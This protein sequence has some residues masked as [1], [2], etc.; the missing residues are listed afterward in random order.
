[1]LDQ[2]FGQP[3]VWNGMAT[4]KA[5]ATFGIVKS[6][7]AESFALETGGQRGATAVGDALAKDVLHTSGYTAPGFLTFDIA[8]DGF[9]QNGTGDLVLSL[10]DNFQSLDCEVV[11]TSTGN[12]TC[13]TTIKVS[14][15]SPI[16]LQL[17]LSSSVGL[18]LTVSAGGSGNIS[19][20]ADFSQTGLI[21][22]IEA[23]DINMQPISGVAITAD[24]GAVYPL[25]VAQ[26]PEP[27]L[28]VLPIVVLLFGSIFYRR[29]SPNTYRRP[30]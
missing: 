20:S 18:T 23:F 24:S 15:A 30:N 28:V 7:A 12:K 16:N 29:R 10:A 3:G 27:R 19:G 17:I 1:M 14:D 21:T 6:Y 4:A 26:V 25:G 11:L 22:S 2:A 5:S 8:L 13:A 9:A